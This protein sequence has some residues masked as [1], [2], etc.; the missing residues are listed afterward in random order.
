MNGKD[1]L[2]LSCVCVGVF[3]HDVSAAGKGAPWESD[4]DKGEK[5]LKGSTLM[6]K[7]SKK[8]PKET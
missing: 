2:F 5:Y 8:T 4:Q 6:W 3:A 7:E 1:T